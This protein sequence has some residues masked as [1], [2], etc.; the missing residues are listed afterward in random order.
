MEDLCTCGGPNGCMI[1]KAEVRKP[2]ED[3]QRAQRYEELDAL[4]TLLDSEWFAEECENGNYH[5]AREFM[6]E[7]CNERDAELTKERQEAGERLL[8]PVVCSCQHQLDG[9]TLPR[10]SDVPL[11]IV[12]YDPHCP[13]SGHSDAALEESRGR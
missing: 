13:I 12:K 1:H 7:L 2:T 5:S 9:G 11:P 6:K 8:R 4:N 10:P 3:E